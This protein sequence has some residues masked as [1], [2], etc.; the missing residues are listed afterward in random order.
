METQDNILA[1][2]STLPKEQL[3]EA[4][5]RIN[6]LLGNTGDSPVITSEL[7]IVYNEMSLAIQRLT[8]QRPAPLSRFKCTRYW[9]SFREGAD[10]LT[11]FAK[12]QLKAR[13]RSEFIQ[14]T[15]LIVR[16]IARQMK[17]EE[18]VRLTVATLAMQLKR[19]GEILDNMFPGY[20]ECG[21]LP[22]VLKKSA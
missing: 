2:L 9:R 6:H 8:G 5:L 14:A 10:E 19:V 18:R 15:R 4:Q 20:A 17:K 7:D 12:D 1:A 11:E 13:T 21:L 3:K 22:I 16:A